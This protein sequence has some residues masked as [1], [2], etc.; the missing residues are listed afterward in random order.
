MKIPRARHGR[1]PRLAVGG[2]TVG[3]VI[4][5]T[6]L[7]ITAAQAAAPGTP[8]YCIETMTCTIADFSGMTMDQRLQFVRGLSDGPAQQFRSGFTYWRAIEGVIEFF[9]DRG[10]GQPGTW[11]SYVDA[12]I[13]EGTERGIAMAAGMDSAGDM[14]NQGADDWRTFLLDLQAGNLGDRITLDHE[15]GVAE[16]ASTNAGVAYAVGRASPSNLENNWFNWSQVFRY[17]MIN[18]ASIRAIPVAGGILGAILDKTNFT[19]VTSAT[20]VYFWTSA[21]WNANAALTLLNDITAQNWP[22]FAIDMYNFLTTGCSSGCSGG[23]QNPP[24]LPSVYDVPGGGAFRTEWQSQG[25]V[26]GTLGDPLNNWYSRGGGQAQDFTGG[27][28]FYS[29][30]TG[31]WAVLTRNGILENYQSRGDA[32]SKLGFPTDNEYSSNGG[33][34]QD[35]Q[36]GYILN[37]SGNIYYTGPFS[38]SSL[39]IRSNANGNYVSA[40]LGYTGGSYAMLRA[41]AASQGSWE[42]WAEIP[43]D[44]GLIALQSVA[45]GKFVSAELGYTGSDYGELRARSSVVGPWETFAMY[46]NS[47]GTYSLRSLANS[48]YVS[49]ELGYTGSNYGELRARAS[50]IGS[51]EEFDNSPAP[52]TCVN[53]GSFT[54]GP[55]ACSGFSTHSVW[56]S[57]G[58]VGLLGKEIWTYANGTVQD[59]TATYQFS[60]LDTTHVWQL[61]AYIPNNYSDASNAHYHFCSPGGGCG[62]GYVN[63]NNY[64]NQWAVFG[65][66]C[67]SDG[68][69]SVVL[70]DD[71]GDVY[72]VIVGAD[73][74]RAVRLSILC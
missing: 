67:T 10:L 27:T 15:W 32:N 46:S 20:N 70:A 68:T 7:G 63:Q 44:N 69:A 41:R 49:A 74:I 51:W 5:A 11:I 13:L 16:Q 14:G 34:R 53:Y 56:Y 28:I 58:G 35:F 33:V 21:A 18:E 31:T 19:D 45:N 9:N 64:T 60:G 65:A 1:W 24:L 12:G 23:G 8:Q 30:S 66:V 48:M 17:V 29:G 3:L 55:G 22:Q 59:S 72:P 50:S 36:H 38:S 61:Q 6:A 73:A 2:V 37:G 26:G 71:G 62:D 57:G 52:P 54:T 39:I 4:S 47:D 25:G 42:T 43:L 40:E